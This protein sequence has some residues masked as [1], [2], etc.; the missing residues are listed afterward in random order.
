MFNRRFPV[1]FYPFFFILGYCV[2]LIF[3]H[4]S[5]GD[6]YRFIDQNGVMHFT[7]VPTE[8]GGELII[9]ERHFD[10]RSNKYERFI[11][12]ISRKYNVDNSLV[13]AII[14]VESNFNS[15]AVSKAGA[16]GLMQL[17]PGTV[18]D[19]RVKDPFDPEQNIEG[20]VRHFKHLLNR[21]EDNLPLALAAYHAGEGAVKRYKGIPPFLST[22]RYIKMVLNQFKK[23][24]K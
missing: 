6:I 21:F 3:P 14:Q 17:M 20:G 12:K 9:K 23:Y 18:E 2:V 15:Q 22:Q 4:K 5:L 7:N 8:S 24:K 11:S 13:K 19:L 1:I 10:P 16:Q